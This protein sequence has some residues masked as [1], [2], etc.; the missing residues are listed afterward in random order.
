MYFFYETGEE[1]I[2]GHVVVCTVLSDMMCW[3]AIHM[4]NGDKRGFMGKSLIMRDWSGSLKVI[5]EFIPD[6]I[7]HDF[8]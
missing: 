5:I 8:L 1:T 2:V 6:K 7:S 3:H 4:G